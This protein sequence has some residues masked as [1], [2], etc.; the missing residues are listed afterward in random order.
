MRRFLRLSTVALATAI[1]LAQPAKYARPP[2]LANVSYGP[3]ERNVMDIWKAK[4]DHPTPVVVNIHGGGFVAGDKTAISPSLLEYC[5]Q[6]GISVATI[7][8]RYATQAPYPAAMQDGARA[9]QFLRSRAKEWNFNP[10]AFAATGGS[11]GA[12]ISLWIGFRD[13]MADTKSDDPVKRESTRLSAIGPVDGQTAYD[14][15]IIARIIDEKTS[16]H[17]ALQKIYG[18]QAREMNTERAFKLFKEASAVTNLTPDDPPVF[19]YYSRPLTGDPPADLAA[20]IHD[21]RFGV[22][23]KERMDRLGIECELHLRKEYSEQ[24]PAKEFYRQMVEFFRRH[25]PQ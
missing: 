22:L 1:A 25:F 6:S 4:S 3:H 8:Y 18:L 2:D 7:N 17:P 15:P 5:L 10:K 19:M 11:A 23:L 16:H 14:P 13:D 24:Q 12:G 9:V 21:P 20:G